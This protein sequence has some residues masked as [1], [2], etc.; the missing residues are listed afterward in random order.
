MEIA[1]CIVYYGKAV[2]HKNGIYKSRI[3]RIT[4]VYRTYLRINNIIVMCRKQTFSFIIQCN[5]FS[6]SVRYCGNYYGVMR[7][8]YV[9]DLDSIHS[10]GTSRITRYIQVF[11]IG[12]DSNLVRAKAFCN[13]IN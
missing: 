2:V 13:R 10:A 5:A 6:V 8:S 9:K 3:S 12:G 4:N 1:I 11:V 7:I